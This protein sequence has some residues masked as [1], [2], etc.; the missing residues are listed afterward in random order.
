MAKKNI[1]IVGTD[2]FNLSELN[3]ID[4]ADE[5]NFHSLG[6]YHDIQKKGVESDVK[7]ILDK[8]RSILDNF[9]GSIDGIIG[10][11]DFPITLI[12]FLLT[13]EYDLPGPSFISGL[14][15]EHKYW[16]RVE[17]KKVIPDHVP[18]F[19]AVNPKENLS[20]KD[21]DLD[22]PFWL[23]PIKA[24]SS[25]LGFKIEN[26]EDLKEALDQIKNKIHVYGDPFNFLMK[27]ADLPAEIEKIDG[28]YCIAE[29]LISGHQCTISGYVYNNEVFVYG[30]V[31]SIN[32]EDQS[33]FF[34]Y[35]YPS[36]LP[37]KVQDRLKEI[38]TKVM[39]QLKFN[40]S[41]F[42]IEYFYDKEK[43]TLNLLEINPRMSQ[44]HSDIY[45]KVGGNSNHK[46]LVELALGENPNFKP[47][48]GKFNFAAK[49]HHCVFED[50]IIKKTPSEEKVKAVEDQYP[51]LV[52]FPEAIEG[53]RLS[54]S[55]KH[56]S[57]SYRLAT[58]FIGAD[59]QDK[60]LKKY[61]D[62]IEQLGYEVE[63]SQ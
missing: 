28:N 39:N 12:A 60:L 52:L 19:R 30:I 29:K 16:S 50:G 36:V 31:D 54:E 22:P 15:C 35:L 32:Y 4:N 2:D 61:N 23:K 46:L 62:I 8:A 58:L 24:Y 43:D 38:S 20:L 10:Y 45:A 34:Y 33:S 44:S 40:N 7:P 3:A 27:K 13:D 56:D 17:Q 42:N 51:D 6:D 48:G 18:D 47:E 11:Y 26:D 49:F 14:Q 63:L 21:I 59:S 57:Y 5:Y 37:E 1:F 25:S 9:D 41:T 53:N 55:H